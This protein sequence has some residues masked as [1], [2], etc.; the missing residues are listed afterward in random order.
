ME[1]AFEMYSLHIFSE[2]IKL[3][4]S[5]DIKNISDIIYALS[6]LQ[7]N[8][9]YLLFVIDSST[10]IRSVS[11]PPKKT[12][13]YGSWKLG[14]L[15]ITQILIPYQYL[16]TTFQSWREVLVFLCHCLW[17]L[18]FDWTTRKHCSPTNQPK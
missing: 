14:L 13:K 12:K 9:R 17:Y 3:L 7:N 4:N 6:Y 11:L 1:R 16:I 18:H 10:K 2:N 5:T 8:A 15:L